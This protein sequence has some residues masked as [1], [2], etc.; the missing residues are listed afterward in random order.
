MQSFG[1]PEFHSITLYLNTPNI[2]HLTHIYF[3]IVK[4]I[5]H[6]N[7]ILKYV[8]MIL[9]HAIRNLRNVYDGK[10]HDRNAINYILKMTHIKK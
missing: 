9:P 8:P 4:F 5:A 2:N 3:L 7:D 6:W 1:L 10:G